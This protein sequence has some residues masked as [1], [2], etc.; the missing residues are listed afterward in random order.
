MTT[1]DTPGAR[2]RTAVAEEEPLQVVGAINAYC[3]LL[4][5]R[6]GLRALQ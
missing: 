1:V 5:Q 6:A 2:L 4:A 3:A